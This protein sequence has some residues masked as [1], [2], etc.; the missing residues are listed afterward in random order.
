MKKIIFR[1]SDYSG[2]KNE[3]GEIIE[4]EHYVEIREKY[5]YK[6]ENEDKYFNLLYKFI[7]DVKEENLINI[8]LGSNYEQ[9]EEDD[10]VDDNNIAK[11]YGNKISTK[12]MDMNL[13]RKE[14]KTKGYIGVLRKTVKLEEQDDDAYDVI[15]EIGSKFDKWSND[16]ENNKQLFLRKMISSACNINLYENFNPKSDNADSLWYWL[17]IFAFRYQLENAYRIGLFKKYK[18]FEYNDSKVKGVVDINRHIKCNI[19]FNG[20]IAYNKRELTY[21]NE[22]MHLI[23]HAYDILNSKYPNEVSA[24]INKNSK[25]YEAICAIREVAPNYKNENIQ[26]LIYKCSRKITHPYYHSYEHLRRVCLL[27]IKNNGISFFDGKSS[28][29]IGVII[30]ISELWERFL[31]NDILSKIKNENMKV[32]YQHEI[33]LKLEKEKKEIKTFTLKS[34]Y[35]IEKDNKRYVLDAKYKLG[36]EKFVSEYDINYIIHDYRQITNYVYLLDAQFGGVIFPYSY[37]EDEKNKNGYCFTYNGE[38]CFYLFALNVPN[39]NNINE[40]IEQFNVNLDNLKKE[41]ETMF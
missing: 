41:I 8:K 28:D 30:N 32:E 24:F 26:A 17:F 13:D 19:P 18:K 1:F 21:D 4:K 20:K 5:N 15:I 6:N 16:N 38:K 14:I 25:A 39:S 9:N 27:I 2:Y 37:N 35:I 7:K 31:Y 22:I 23:L 40:W 3:D 10:E 29:I 33:K 36:W 12:I 11:S 34:D